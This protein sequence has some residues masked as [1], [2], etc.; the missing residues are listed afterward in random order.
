MAEHGYVA[1]KIFASYLTDRANTDD[2]ND[3][4]DK[5]DNG[6]KNGNDE[7]SHVPTT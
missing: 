1:T 7:E 6:E 4:D 5:D 2:R 3:K